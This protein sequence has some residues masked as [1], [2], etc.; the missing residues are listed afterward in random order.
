[1]TRVLKLIVLVPIAVLCVAFAVANR[2]VVAVS[3]DP[4]VAN[5]PALAIVAPMF[6]LVFILLMAGVVMGGVATWLGQGRHRKAARRA[7]ADLDA[8]HTQIE[9]LK[10]ELAIER[11]RAADQRP[12]QPALAY[13]GAA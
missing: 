10:T 1:M 4:F 12:A 3:F 9:Q 2:Q 8:L 6:L 5:D 11:R 13:E 7:Q